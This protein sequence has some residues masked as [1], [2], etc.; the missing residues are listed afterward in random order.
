MNH[1]LGFAEASWQMEQ[2]TLWDT[3]ALSFLWQSFGARTVENCIYSKTSHIYSQ[4]FYE[5]L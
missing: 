1:G 5:H 4:C 3:E 2:S